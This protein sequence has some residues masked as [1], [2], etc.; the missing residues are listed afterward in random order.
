MLGITQT[1]IRSHRL[2][3]IVAFAKVVFF[4]L[5]FVRMASGITLHNRRIFGNVFIS[6]LFLNRM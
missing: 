1:S 6:R 5:V 3:Y 2:L 4:S